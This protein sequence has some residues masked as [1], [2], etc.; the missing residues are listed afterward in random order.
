MMV[1]QM[2]VDGTSDARRWADTISD[3][4][5]LEDSQHNIYKFDKFR[6]FV[7]TTL[8]L[9]KPCDLHKFRLSCFEMSDENS[10]KYH[11]SVRSWIL[12]ALQHNLRVF[13][14]SHDMLDG[15]LPLSVFTCAS[16][17]DASFSSFIS[18]HHIEVINLPFIRQLCLNGLELN[19]GFIDKLF[20]GCPVLEF[21]DLVHCCRKLSMN[22]QSLKCLKLGCS[23]QSIEMN[24]GNRVLLINTPNLLSFHCSICLNPTTGLL[25]MPSL[26]S[27]SIYSYVHY[28]STSSI[29]IGLSNVQNLKLVGEG[30]KECLENEMPNCPQ[31]SNLKNLSVASLCLSCHFHLL[32]SFLNQCPNLEKLSLYYGPCRCQVKVHGNQESLKIAPFKGKQLET[33]EVKFLKNGI[34]RNFSQVVKY[35]EDI[36]EN[37]GAQISMTTAHSLLII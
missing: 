17:V 30:I 23:C 4:R 36:T 6:E 3:D 34:D 25:K 20:S 29:L 9:R 19:Q 2:L 35:V 18:L 33:V 7:S 37:S 1:H 5:E 28:S 27:A 13:E 31:L 21:L 15:S 14:I 12:Y 26:T 10:D 24:T 16:L 22:S 11:V 8:L 32:A